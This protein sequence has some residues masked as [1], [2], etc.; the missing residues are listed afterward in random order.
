MKAKNDENTSRRNARSQQSTA[1]TKIHKW[2]LLKLCLRNAPKLELDYPAR[3]DP[4]NRRRITANIRTESAVPTVNSKG[5]NPQV[6][7]AQ[8]LS[9]ECSESRKTENFLISK[10]E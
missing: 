2:T 10:I 8:A 6:D 4:V 7:T 1:R 9:E 3:K 5:K